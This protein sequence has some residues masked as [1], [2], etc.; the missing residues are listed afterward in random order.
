MLSDCITQFQKEL[1][2]E[3]PIPVSTDG[4]YTLTLD[5]D[6]KIEMKETKEGT[7]FFSK[8]VPCPSTKVEDFF[9]DLLSANLFGQAT[10]GAILGMTADGKYLTLSRII[11]YNIHYDGF[12]KTIEEFINVLSFWRE[13]ALAKK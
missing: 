5:N 2:F 9:C 10:R 8:F 1:R 13:Q 11:D 3:I 12:R 6:V 7:T 4:T